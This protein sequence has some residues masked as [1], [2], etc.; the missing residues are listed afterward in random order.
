M[1]F[2]DTAFERLSR[3]SPEIS[4][5]IISFVNLTQDLPEDRGI[6]LGVFV[7]GTNAGASLYIP[8]LSKGGNVF[9]LDTVF[10]PAE[11]QFFP[12]IESYVMQSIMSNVTNIG[13][14]TNIPSTVVQN[15][16]VRA[17]V[18]P[19]R[20][21]KHAYAGTML[22]EAAYQMSPAY[23]K[24]FIE[25]IASDATF[26]KTL[27]KVGID[28]GSLLGTLTKQAESTTTITNLSEPGFGL[29]VIV[30]G[31]GLPNDTVQSILSNGYAFIGQHDNPRFAIQYDAL[32][33]GY[34]TL[35]SAVE[36]SVYQVILKDGSSKMGFVPPKLRSIGE[37]VDN[38]LSVQKA[39]FAPRL[40]ANETTNQCCKVILFEDGT[41]ATY[42]ANPV[43]KATS[44]S[45]LDEA[46]GMLADAGKVHSI[47]EIAPKMNGDSLR[48]FIVTD[49]GWI[50]PL[51]IYKK[52]VNMIGITY[53]IGSS[54]GT[55]THVHVSDN[56]H[57]S[58]VN[59]GGDVFIRS[60]AVFVEAEPTNVELETS[61][62]VASMK[63]NSFLSANMQPM[64]IRREGWDFY[65][66]GAPIGQE[67][68]L[69]K[70][71]AEEERLEANIV[72][73]LLKEASEKSLVKFWISK[74]AA[75]NTMDASYTQGVTPPAQEQLFDNVQPDFNKIQQAAQ[76]N[77]RSVLEA[78][79]ISEFVN[80]PDMFETLGSYLPIIR[81]AIDKLGRSIFLLRLNINNMSNLVDTSYL[82]GVMISLRN[83]YR[84]LG[85]SYLK[86]TQ[87]STSSYENN[88]ESTTGEVV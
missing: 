33:D 62:S 3:T 24:A 32:N 39:V 85:D 19:P 38:S 47:T 1:N 65:L 27:Q 12:L 84:N 8:V 40:K 18:D 10:N 41:Y 74:E 26:G 86:L 17:L 48:G 51:T 68:D 83:T 11:G 61:V 9:P 15:P 78:T 36:G 75:I 21:G 50:G 76:V 54:D 77:D 42:E 37:I 59:Q 31:S 2:S 72:T 25:K 63:R 82:S 13:A 45:S 88:Q 34:T 14:A 71:L 64:A 46:V 70:R 7:L 80:D 53:H 69:A 55:V 49:R 29:K 58:V 43:I 44:T 28:I 81:E 20:T 67:V 73:S 5:Y 30:E 16:S 23:K 56:I 79:I 6:E 57:G 22:E 4:R 35:Q 66:N 52:S 60:N 87:L